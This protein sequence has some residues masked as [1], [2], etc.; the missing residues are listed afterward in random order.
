MDDSCSFPGCRR[1]Q[2]QFQQSRPRR[3]IPLDRDP[4][5]SQQHARGPGLGSSTAASVLGSR[6][7][8]DGRRGHDTIDRIFEHGGTENRREGDNCPRLENLARNFMCISGSGEDQLAFL[9][10]QEQFRQMRALVRQ[11]PQM[12]NA[13]IQQIGQTNPQLLQLISQNQEAFIR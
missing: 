10:D 13:V 8:G 7:A 3:R 2:S 11:D 6:R 1:S 5:L 4:I 12:L 9:R